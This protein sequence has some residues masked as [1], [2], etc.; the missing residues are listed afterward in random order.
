M[1]TF[2]LPLP[3]DQVDS[4][5]ARCFFLNESFPVIP[6][7]FGR[8][9]PIP[10]G[11]ANPEFDDCGWAQATEWEEDFVGF[12]IL[13]PGCDNGS[14]VS[15]MEV[16]GQ[17]LICQNNVDWGN[18]QFIWGDDLDN[19]NRLLCRYTTPSSSQ[20]VVTMVMVVAICLSLSVSLITFD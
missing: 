17:P 20:G 18:S 3:M 12:G 6:G 14:L 9:K 16:N 7:C 5:H 15:T 8:R 4:S 2:S 13:P 11:W 19:D 1:L 10:E